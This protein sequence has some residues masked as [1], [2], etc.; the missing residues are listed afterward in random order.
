M[1]DIIYAIKIPLLISPSETF[2]VPD[3]LLLVIIKII[4]FFSIMKHGN[5]AIRFHFSKFVL[6]DFSLCCFHTAASIYNNWE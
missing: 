1:R 4:L 2:S 3:F 5:I 6:Q